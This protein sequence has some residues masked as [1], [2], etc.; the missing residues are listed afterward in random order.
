MVFLGLMLIHVVLPIGG[1]AE[2]D[3][4]LS[5]WL[6][7][8]RSP[9]QE[10][11]SWVGSTLAGGHV[12]PAVIGLCLAFFLITKRWLLAAFVLFAVAL[13][14]ATYRATSMIIDR[15]RPD[16][17]RLE[18]LPVH[19][20][21]PSGHTAASIA[22][23]G[24]LLLL[25]A[26]RI[27][28]TAFRIVAVLVGHRDSAL[29]RLVADVSRHAPRHRRRRRSAHGAR[30]A[31]AHRLRRARLARRRRAPRRRR[32]AMTRVAVIAHAG[33]SLGGGLDELRDVLRNAGVEDPYWTEVPKSKYVPERVEKALAEGA[34]TIFVWGGD[35]TVQRCVDVMAGSDA[36]LAIIPAGT[37]NL[38]ASN[39]GI[40]DDI[41]E[42]V[43]VGLHGRERR[44]DVG[45]INGE[46]FAVMAGAG[47]DA[48][49]IRD[50]DGGPKDKFGRLAYIWAASKNLRVEPF[51]ARIEVNG[52]LWYDDDA[53]CLLVGN[54]GALF[55]GLEAFD[56]ASPED[57]Q[58]EVGVTHA[59]SLGQW[60]RTVARTAIG[61]AESSPFV[62]VTK[63]KR[64]DVEFDR[65]VP[66]ELD[67]GDRDEVKRLKVKVKPQAL[68]VMV[69]QE[70]P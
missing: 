30:R 17:E 26:S 56:N 15:D 2:A 21:Y 29:R 62:Q 70:E 4:D 20:S 46:H 48:R 51:K 11:A 25:L 9:G 49:M 59:E 43:E 28:S 57:G 66:Y 35:G 18:Q 47:L 42:A 32:G 63:A 53:S 37:A 50:T 3:A 58:L 68:T 54:V 31:R 8:N 13:E 7:D 19:D 52:D 22:L 67:G 40:P 61:S 45:K 36:R 24:G 44:L 6:A 16:V 10:D 69:P 14:S 34:E 33:K 60:A 12:I 39:L 27:Q 41:A 23:Y 65:K 38:F 55:G 5:E 64:I 1:L